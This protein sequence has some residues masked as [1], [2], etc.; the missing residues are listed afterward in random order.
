MRRAPRFDVHGRRCRRRCGRA[1]ARR[2]ACPATSPVGAP[3]TVAPPAGWRRRGRVADGRRARR[4]GRRWS[5]QSAR[6][7]PPVFGRRLPA[8]RAFA[9]ALRLR[10]HGRSGSSRARRVAPSRTRF[11]GLGCGSSN[12]SRSTKAP[13]QSGH[14]HR[15]LGG[16]DAEARDR[17]EIGDDL[18]SR[19]ALASRAC[20][21]GRKPA[22]RCRCA[23][24]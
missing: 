19:A 15:R 9:A 13:R 11:L 24:L 8:D 14:A 23:H 5:P 20:A 7:R 12:W 3:E 1:S 4:E 2:G 18:F 21:T 17:P 22:T 6:R 10:R 16:A